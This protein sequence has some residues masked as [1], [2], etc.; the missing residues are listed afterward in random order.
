MLENVAD[1]LWIDDGK[2]FHEVRSSLQDAG[3]LVHWRIVCPKDIGVPMHR[4][5]L[6]VVAVNWDLRFDFAWPS[7]QAQHR[8]SA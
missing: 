4:Q 1:A 6:Y 3:Y 8:E 2:Q 5:R 7:T